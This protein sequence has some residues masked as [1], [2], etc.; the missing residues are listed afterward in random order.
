M[1]VMMFTGIGLFALAWFQ[2]VVT[3]LEFPHPKSP[4]PTTSACLPNPRGGNSPVPHA[5]I[6]EGPDGRITRNED[7]EAPSSS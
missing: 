4:F 3:F 6:A 2:A 1:I 5:P 7:G